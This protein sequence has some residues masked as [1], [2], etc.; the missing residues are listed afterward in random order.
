MSTYLAKFTDYA[1]ELGAAIRLMSDSDPEFGRELA[2][3]ETSSAAFVVCDAFSEFWAAWHGGQDSRLYS[4]GSR[5]CHEFNYIH[6]A[7]EID[8]GGSQV[9]EFYACLCVA[10]GAD[11]E[12][13]AEFFGTEK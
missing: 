9:R 4:L 2:S 8:E 3:D 11:D 10:F 6:R 12:I 13:R 1:P 7:S 5:F